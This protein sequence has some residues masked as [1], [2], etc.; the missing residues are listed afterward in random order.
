[1]W[2][3][4]Q[5]GKNIHEKEVDEIVVLD[6]SGRQQKPLRI[7]TQIKEIASEAFMPLGYGGG[8]TKL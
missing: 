7:L 3:T 6:I 4:P 8:I 1:M 5:Y 2:V